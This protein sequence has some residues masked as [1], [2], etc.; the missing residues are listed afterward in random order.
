MLCSGF[1]YYIC[2]ICCANSFQCENI[3]S[4][5]VQTVALMDSFK[6]SV[7]QFLFLF[8]FFW[9]GG[10]IEELLLHAP[11]LRFQLFSLQTIISLSAEDITRNIT[12]E[13]LRLFIFKTIAVK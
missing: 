5:F 11:N 13:F 6:F 3:Q 8:L 4:I 1:S 7:E 10:D 2:Q 9:V 12:I